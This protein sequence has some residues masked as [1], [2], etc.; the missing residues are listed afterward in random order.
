MS[1]ADRR[2]APRFEFVGEQLGSIHGLEPL[3]VRN[4]G[5][6]GALVES[7]APILVGSILV[8]NM[9]HGMEPVPQKSVPRSGTSRRQATEAT[10]SS[11][12][13]VSSSSTWMNETRAWIDEV[14]TA[15]LAP[16]TVDEA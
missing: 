14:F 15:Q 1:N 7:V 12:W 6:E 13:W 5:R 2:Q 16:V 10:G 11:T 3:R 9:I 4:L 8:L